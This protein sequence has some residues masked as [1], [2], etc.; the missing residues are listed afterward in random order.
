[1]TYHS[2]YEKLE[3]YQ[4][5]FIKKSL[6]FLTLGIFHCNY[7]K[8]ALRKNIGYI[9]SNIKILPHGSDENVRYKKED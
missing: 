7:Q 5:K 4:K 2:V 1:M 9:P 3:P 8:R 6:S